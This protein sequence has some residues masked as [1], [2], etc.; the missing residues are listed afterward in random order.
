MTRRRITL[1]LTALSL[2]A[3]TTAPAAL[4]DGCR[5]GTSPTPATGVVHAA[6]E[7]GEVAGQGEVFHETLEPATCV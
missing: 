3:V 6:G 4:A 7:V 2:A 5:A 1:S